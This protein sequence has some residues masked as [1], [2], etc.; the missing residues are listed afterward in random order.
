[1]EDKNGESFRD[2]AYQYL[3][4]QIVDCRLKPGDILDEKKYIAELGISRTPVREAIKSLAE[5]EFVQ[6]MPRRGTIVAPISVSD[7]KQVYEMRLLL[8][9]YIIRQITG[10]TDHERLVEF[11]ELF[12]KTESAEDLSLD[13]LD[14]QFHLYLAECAH[15][16]FL[17]KMQEH[18][19]AQ[20]YRVRVLSNKDAPG[21]FE[22]AWKEHAELIDKLLAEDEEG[23]VRVAVSHLENSQKGYG[24][25]FTNQTYFIL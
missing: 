15:N 5:E 8:E 13:D 22:H 7:V 14:R 20:S 21:R 2:I 16:R 1:M 6:V 18:L 3:K 11:R 25:I 24:D 12:E 9:P 17:Y 23:A 10:R 4:K 19:M